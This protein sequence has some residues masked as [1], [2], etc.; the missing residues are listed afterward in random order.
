MNNKLIAKKIK[1]CGVV[2]YEI[3]NQGYQSNDLKKTKRLV[4]MQIDFPEVRVESRGQ[5]LNR[6]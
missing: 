2:V 1:I 6:K 5:K 4:Y 3:R